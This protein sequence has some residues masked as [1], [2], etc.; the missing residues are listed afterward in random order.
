MDSN[1]ADGYILQG[2]PFDYYDSSL[3]TEV[4]KIAA[5]NN[6]TDLLLTASDL[7]PGAYSFHCVLSPDNRL[8]VTS[9]VLVGKHGHLE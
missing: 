2:C 4:C 1:S 7:G 6:G 9:Y 3:T 8:S 5:D